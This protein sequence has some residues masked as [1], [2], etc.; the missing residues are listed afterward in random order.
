V[1]L[2]GAAAGT[3]PSDEVEQLTT[4]LPELN[5]GQT[6]WVSTLWRGASEDATSFRLEADG[7]G[8]ISIDYPEN[9][10][11]YSSLYK[12]ST[13]LAEDTDYASFK[14][15]VGNDMIGNK[16]IDLEV[17]YCQ[18]RSGK[19][20]NNGNGGDHVRRNLRVTLPVVAFNGPAVEQVTTSVGPLKAGTAEWVSVAYKANKPGVTGARL[21]ATPPSGAT[22]TYPNEGTS[23]GFASDADLSVGETDSAS[24][25]IDTGTLTPGNHTVQLDLAYGNGQHLAGTVTLVVS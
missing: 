13:L 24:I 8:G 20:N 3:R 7:P 2:V 1:W 22:V 10:P 17:T 15:H 14:V 4:T 18:E 6:A 12:D 21:T 9:T 11:G 19:C 5:P 25:K 16:T 23:S